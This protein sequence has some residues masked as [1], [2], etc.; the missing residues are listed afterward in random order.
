YRHCVRFVGLAA[1]LALAGCQTT[2]MHP[3]ASPGFATIATPAGVGLKVTRGTRNAAGNLIAGPLAY[4]N[5]AGRFA[6]IYEKD[7]EA[8]QSACDGECLKTYGPLSAPATARTE[9]DWS[10][11]E[12][13]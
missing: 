4:T 8:G 12:R 10:I 6:F 11:L 13:G 3:E 1:I 5:E 2:A 7:S 9:G